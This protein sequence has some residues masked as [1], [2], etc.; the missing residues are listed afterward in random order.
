MDD[1]A[2]TAP[3]GATEPGPEPEDEAGPVSGETV[4]ASAEG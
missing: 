2:D 3:A 1:D 4:A